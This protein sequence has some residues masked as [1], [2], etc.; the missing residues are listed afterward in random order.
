MIKLKAKAEKE[1]RSLNN[2]V[3][4]ILMSAVEDEPNESTLAAM[5]DAKEGRELEALDLKKFKEF[6]ASL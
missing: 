2:S 1:H 6:V 4:V 5:T 3:A